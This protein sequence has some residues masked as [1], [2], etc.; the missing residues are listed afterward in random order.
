VTGSHRDEAVP[1]FDDR[2]VTPEVGDEGG[3]SGDVEVG[4]ELDTG[5]GSEA[6]ETWRPAKNEHDAVARDESGEGRR[7]P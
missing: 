1:E 3:T 6:T 5:G 2:R 7:S 4:V